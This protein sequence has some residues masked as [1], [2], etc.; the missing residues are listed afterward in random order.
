M[1]LTLKCPICNKQLVLKKS[2]P[3]DTN[4][5]HT[6]SL[7]TYKCGHAFLTDPVHK[8][9]LKLDS[10]DG[11]K[12]ARQYQIE[13]IDFIV[14]GTEENPQGFNCIIGD[15]MRLGKTPQALLALA[16]DYE[17]RTPC[18]I[19]VKAANLWQWIREYKIWTDSLP[20]GIFPI[21][22][23]KGFI[24]PGFSAYIISMDT[25]S[26]EGTCKHC[27]HGMNNHDDV[28]HCNKKSCRC[29]KAESTGDSMVE[30]LLPMNFKLVIADE[31]HSFKNTDSNRSKALTQFLYGINKTEI[32]QHINFQ[33]AMCKHQW[34]ETI[35]IDITKE[36]QTASK[37]SYCPNC[38][39]FCH[40]R[41]QRENIN[42]EKKCGI[43]PLTGTAIKNAAD[44]L[45]V[46]LNLVAPTRFPSLTQFQ[47]QYLMKNATNRWVV[48]PMAMNAFK[49]A[50]APYFL[51]R[52]KEDVYTDLPEINRM[53]TVIEVMDEN[54]K[55]AYN[56]VLD[57]LEVEVSRNNYSYF[58]TIAELTL[59]RQICGLAKVDW[60]ANYL[61]ASMLDSDTERYAVGIH[62]HAVRDNLALKLS[63]LG[64]LKLSGEDNAEKK[65][66]IMR[67]FEHSPERI[68][69]IN[70]LAGGVGMDFHYC[71]NVLILERQFSSADE[72]QFEFRFY[73]P[74]REI[75]GHNN[76]NVEYVIAKGTIDQW[77][78]E[79]I[80]QKR[81]IFGETIGTNWSLQNDQK[82]FKNLVDST[83]AGR[84]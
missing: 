55:K 78:Y 14:N 73:N 83:I 7:Q 75:M 40:Q 65:D 26:R 61:E 62:H 47:R 77:F 51:R 50:I 32:T 20:N 12:H 60:T 13:G 42:V 76:T 74:D 69:I 2:F 80:E 6:S 82:T 34:V 18:L 56:R 39:T 71:H 58:S 38:H 44:E 63:H 3:L 57:S 5:V 54:L 48:A 11:T 64:V 19:I 35:T 30:K 46:P 49:K 43:I 33:C 28:G 37:S 22:G 4:N 81:Q 15:Q 67:G 23:T 21:V 8:R 16:S 27:K 31:A 70:M 59:L 1:K 24:P 29:M 10:V 66:E 52:E 53:F 84:L 72:E 17:N 41:F 36:Q 45:F 79:L 25:F 9:S 68:L